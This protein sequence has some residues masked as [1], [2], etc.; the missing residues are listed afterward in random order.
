MAI[1]KVY[2]VPQAAEVTTLSPWTIWAMLTRGEL[3]RTKIGRRTVIKE[4]EL[5][6]LFKE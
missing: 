1:E 4:S 2:T 6:K 3:K 5:E